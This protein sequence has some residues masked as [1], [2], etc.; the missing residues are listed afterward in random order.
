MDNYTSDSSDSDNGTKTLDLSYL[1]L[2]SNSVA[3]N[4]DSVK[5]PENVETLL[6]RHN[7][8]TYTPGNLAKFINLHV[9]DISNCGLIKLPDSLSDCPLTTLIAKNNN[10]F[11]D[12]LPKSL[13]A[14]NTLRE[15]NLSGNQLSEF[16]EQILELQGLRY[17]YLGGNV[18]SRIT[19]D[20]WKLQRYGNYW[21]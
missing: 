2:D 11:N 9:L 4:F 6:L 3:D 8:L 13:E 17:L 16:P 14:F 19:Q 15:L 10:L 20:I 5:N 12:S 1:S 21:Y 18:I 7:R